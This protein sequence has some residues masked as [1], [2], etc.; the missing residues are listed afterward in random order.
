MKS[1]LIT[2]FLLATV[3]CLGQS[4]S[5]AQTPQG[6]PQNN[7]FFSEN[8]QEPDQGVD[9]SAGG[10]GEPALPINNWLALLPLSGVLL[11]IYFI[12][13]RKNNLA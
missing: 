5:Q 2:L 7:Q 6:E 12:H 9:A 8:Y 1:I 3:F 13:K 11:G 4:F 10:P